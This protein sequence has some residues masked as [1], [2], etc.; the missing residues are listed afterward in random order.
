MAQAIKTLGPR[1]LTPRPKTN[2]R[3]GYQHRQWRK[4]ILLKNPI[5]QSCRCKRSTDV[6]HIIPLN[7][8][9]A[10]FDPANV[11]ALCHSCHSA[12]TWKE[13]RNRCGE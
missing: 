6:D 10:P 3:Y 13:M 5:C 4:V 1:V 11:Q 8:G 12:K 2:E 7:K 9:G